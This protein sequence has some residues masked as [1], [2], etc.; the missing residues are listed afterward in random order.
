MQLK[1]FANDF[2]PKE[3]QSKANFTRTYF[4]DATNSETET[5]PVV[6][7]FVM[8]CC[9]AIFSALVFFQAPPFFFL[10]WHSKPKDFFLFYST[11]WYCTV[12][13]Y[14]PIQYAMSLFYCYFGTYSV[15]GIPRNR[16]RKQQPYCR[17]VGRKGRRKR[18][19]VFIS[20]RSELPVFTTRSDKNDV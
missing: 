17:S 14:G 5:F 16:N 8:R 4:Y 10:P 7:N 18:G 11:P 12:L 9:A 3:R 13:L 19:G 15:S 2:N 1:V 6:R 20:Q